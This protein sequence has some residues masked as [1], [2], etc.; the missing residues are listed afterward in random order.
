M[1][2]DHAWG[3]AKRGGWLYIGCLEARLGRRLTARRLPGPPPAVRLAE[4]AFARPVG[5]LGGG[6]S[7]PVIVGG[8]SRWAGEVALESD[9]EL[10]C[11]IV[12]PALGTS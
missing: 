7:M 8:Q 10:F 1:V 3:A 12:P 5:R 4:R 6:G 9:F 11:E 2:H